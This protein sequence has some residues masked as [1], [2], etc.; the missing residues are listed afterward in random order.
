VYDAFKVRN[1]S[2]K[3]VHASRCTLFANL[4][5]FLR[6]TRF[7]IVHSIGDS[8]D[9]RFMGGIS[10]YIPFTSS[11]LVVSN[12]SLCGIP[13]WPVFIL[14]ILF[15]RCFLWDMSI[16]LVFSIIFVY[17]FGGLLFFSFILF[18]YIWWF[19]FFPSYSVV[20][21]N[22]NIMFGIIGLFIT[23]RNMKIVR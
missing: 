22:Y 10:A 15:W 13:F 7:I 21:T 23:S 9:I 8:Q 17:W 1:A 4:V 3:S 20:E 19:Y 12:F 5:F 18:C 14:R 11:C 2:A 16:Y 6:C